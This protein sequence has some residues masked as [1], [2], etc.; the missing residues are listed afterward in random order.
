MGL[1]MND[2]EQ[3]NELNLYFFS[4]LTLTPLPLYLTIYGG[5][6]QKQSSFL[7]ETLRVNQ[8]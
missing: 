3:A 2:F 6:I 4:T 8:Y 5:F 1:D 7:V